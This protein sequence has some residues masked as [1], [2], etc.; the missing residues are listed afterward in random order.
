MRKT[1]DR[2][3]TKR[4]QVKRSRLQASSQALRP[5]RAPLAALRSDPS[6]GARRAAGAGRAEEEAGW[7]RGR[8]EKGQGTLPTKLSEQP[9]TLQI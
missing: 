9:A 3:Q 4:K 8:V 1:K 6:S 5:S 2:T 7:G